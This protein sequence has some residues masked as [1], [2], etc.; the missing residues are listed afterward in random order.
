[1]TETH[2][3]RL[4]QDLAPLREA[5]F[6]H[7]L[8][9]LL[10]DETALRRFMTVHVFAVWDFQ[11]LLKA[12]QRHVTCVEVPWL[13]TADPAA[14]RWVNEIV[15]D[16]ESDEAPGGGWLS[17]FELYLRAMEE[18]GADRGPVQAFL[19]ALRGRTRVDRALGCLPASVAVLASPFVL[20]TLDIATRGSDVEVAAAFAYGR[21]EVIPDMFRRVVERLAGGAPAAWGTFRYYLQRHIGTDAERHGPA[22]RRLVAAL[23]GADAVRWRAATAAAR[24]SL[25]ARL[26]LWDALAADLRVALVA[27]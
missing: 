25:A 7:P 11:S 23:C 18:C 21:E 14:R 27:S 16:E 26:A 22:A 12:L 3:A 13:P 24:R 6:A 15:L 1:M 2:A 9:D 17:H 10:A 8:Y 19:V 4:E 20:T 5:L